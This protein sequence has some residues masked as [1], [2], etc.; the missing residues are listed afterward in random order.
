MNLD[1]SKLQ[2]KS[3]VEK[4]FNDTSYGNI[5]R[6]KGFI[7]DE[8]IAISKT[9]SGEIHWLELNATKNEMTFKPASDGQ[10]VLIVIGEHLN[11]TAIEAYFKI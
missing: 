8:D 7:V 10:K 1:F 9:G 2:L 4:L 5:F 3:I 11:K 6:I